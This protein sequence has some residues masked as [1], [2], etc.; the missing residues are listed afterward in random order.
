MTEPRTVRVADATGNQGG[1]AVRS[2]LACPELWRVRELTRNPDGPRA[3]IFAALGVEVVG[4]DMGKAALLHASFTGAYMA[5]S[6]QH[7]RTAGPPLQCYLPLGVFDGA[8]PH[9]KVLQMVA[10]R[11]IG[12]FARILFEN[13]GHFIG[14]GFELAGGDL[15]LQEII[16][17]VGIVSDRRGVGYRRI[18][19]RIMWMMGGADRMVA[20]LARRGRQA[21][22]AAL[23]QVHSCLLTLEGMVRATDMSRGRS[24]KAITTQS[25]N[26]LNLLGAI[27]SGRRCG[28]REPFTWLVGKWRRPNTL[29]SRSTAGWIRRAHG[30]VGYWWVGV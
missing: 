16:H 12:I 23:H 17:T 2:F 26:R 4:G 7:Y 14:R 5:F 20:W 6:L 11:A 9:S 10:G 15:T 3:R 25:G 13:P 21:D 19:G 8:I 28:W 18:P 27:A 1:A 30:V 29:S 22:I 24:R